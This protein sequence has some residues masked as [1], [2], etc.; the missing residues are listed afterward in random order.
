MSPF[1]LKKI[2][3]IWNYGADETISGPKNIADHVKGHLEKEFP[4]GRFEYKESFFEYEFIYLKFSYCMRFQI[5][6][7][8]KNSVDICQFRFIIT[9][10]EID[11]VW[12]AMHP[13]SDY[14]LSSWLDI[15]D[16]ASITDLKSFRSPKLT[17]I[18]GEQ[19]ARVVNEIGF[20]WEFGCKPTMQ[21][22]HDV[23][24]LKVYCEKLLEPKKIKNTKPE[25][26]ISTLCKCL[27]I[28]NLPWRQTFDDLY[29]KKIL[30]ENF[31]PKWKTS[32]EDF[33]SAWAQMNS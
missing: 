5:K 27:I 25:V 9:S 14:V 19:M 6:S 17:S 8:G 16:L 32:L 13:D 10:L 21:S 24:G 1:F 4:N 22:I 18:N 28:Q 33:D 23:Q 7:Y 2:P 12:K 11:A 15:E 20:L 29:K 3:S 31:D 26:L 30:S